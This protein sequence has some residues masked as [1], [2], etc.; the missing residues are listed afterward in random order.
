MVR[1]CSCLATDS[2]HTV[3]QLAISYRRKSQMCQKTVDPQEKHKII[4]RELAVVLRGQFPTEAGKTL[5]LSS[6]RKQPT[7]LVPDHSRIW[8]SVV[9]AACPLLF[10]HHKVQ[11]MVLWLLLIPGLLP[12]CSH[13]QQLIIFYLWGWVWFHSLSPTARLESGAYPIWFA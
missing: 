3:I 9:G 1:F 12:F 10:P 8:R 5:Q 2:C 11:A 4:Y 6:L 13:K 7:W